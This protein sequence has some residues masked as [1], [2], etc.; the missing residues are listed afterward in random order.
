MQG[1]DVLFR[2]KDYKRDGQWF[3]D[4][5]HATEF[6]RRFLLHVLPFRFVRIRYFGLLANCYRQQN[7]ER[8]RTLLGLAPLEPP[9][10]GITF[11]AQWQR[12]GRLVPG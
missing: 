12:I 1:E 10:P 3:T 7:L 5:I 11:Q 4:Q 8:C 9:P 6:I 2:Y